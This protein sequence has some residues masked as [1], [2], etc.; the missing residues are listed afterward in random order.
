MKKYKI[1]FFDIDMDSL[2]PI[3]DCRLSARTASSL[4]HKGF[5]YLQDMT[6][7]TRNQ[8]FRTRNLGKKSQKELEEKLIEYELQYADEKTIRLRG[9]CFDLVYFR[10]GIG[11]TIGIFVIASCVTAKNG[12]EKSKK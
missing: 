3:N 9:M 1:D 4:T 8:V 2:I 12:D 6:H 11:V 5:V 7:F 10:T